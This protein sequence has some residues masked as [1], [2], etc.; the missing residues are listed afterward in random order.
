MEAGEGCV[1]VRTPSAALLLILR[2]NVTAYGDLLL[3]QTPYTSIDGVI[4]ILLQ[5]SF[6]SP[7][8]L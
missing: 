5:F 2:K 1:A 6:H 4:Y 7:P 8:S 3:H